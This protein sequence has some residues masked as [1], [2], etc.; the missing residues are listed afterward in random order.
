MN[1]KCQK[2]MTRKTL[3]TATVGSTSSSTPAV[4]EHLRVEFMNSLK[5]SEAE[6]KK[7]IDAFEG[8]PLSDAA[9]YATVK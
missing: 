8:T 2:N 9:V 6:I 1:E 5:S 3:W 4:T 7:K